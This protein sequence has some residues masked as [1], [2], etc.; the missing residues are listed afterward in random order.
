MTPFPGRWR[1]QDKDNQGG[2]LRLQ[3]QDSEH[4]IVHP[5]TVIPKNMKG[6]T[7]GSARGGEGGNAEKYHE[8]RYKG[9]VSAMFGYTC[10]CYTELFLLY[11]VCRKIVYMYILVST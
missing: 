3:E 11:Y 8:K 6:V 2:Q 7:K 10:N 9:S 5:G 1:R 4:E